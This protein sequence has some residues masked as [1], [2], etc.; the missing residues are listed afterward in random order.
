MGHFNA[1]WTWQRDYLTGKRL[2]VPLI[3]LWAYD[4]LSLFGRDLPLISESR[5]HR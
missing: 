1:G 5:R 4:H 2:R 3:K